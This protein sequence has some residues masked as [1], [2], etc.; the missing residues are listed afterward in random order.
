MIVWTIRPTGPAGD[1]SDETLP[2]LDADW[3]P[4]LDIYET[5]D[6]FF[7]VLCVPGVGAEDLDLTV[8]GTSITISGR[9]VTPIPPRVRAVY[10]ESPRGRFLRR[11]R[12]PTTCD[13]EAI[14][15]QLANGQLVVRVPKRND[16]PRRVP[17][18]GVEG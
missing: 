2:G 11:L 13:T 10:L 3:Q 14:G 15:T 1:I 6:E 18:R 12:L 7:L 5:A 9:R 17:V 4:P 16:G 8:L